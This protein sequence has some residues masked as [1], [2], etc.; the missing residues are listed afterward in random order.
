MRKQI[1]NTIPPPSFL[2]AVGIWSPPVI[3][4]WAVIAKNN[5]LYNTLP[6]F[7]V[8][9]A[10]EVMK[11]LIATHGKSKLSGQEEVSNT[12]AKIIYD[13]LDAN[14][15]VYQVVPHKDVRSRMNICFRVRNGDSE[16]ESTFLEGAES[17]ML[18][19]LKGISETTLVQYYILIIRRPSNGRWYPY[20]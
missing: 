12:K 13:I 10:G 1:L 2:H 3:F 7:G 4:N 14:P 17:R 16:S 5:S 6:I 8:W 18:K 9:I 15:E 20:L 11:L 19:G